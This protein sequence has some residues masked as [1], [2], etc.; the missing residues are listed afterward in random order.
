MWTNPS[1]DLL[2]RYFSGIVENILKEIV[3]RV[4]M[5]K[6]VMTIYGYGNYI[7]AS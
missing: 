2:P 6:V 7:F 5:S 1:F 4:A 3:L